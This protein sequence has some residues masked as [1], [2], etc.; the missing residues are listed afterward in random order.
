MQLLVGNKK[1]SA[2]LFFVLVEEKAIHQAL[3]AAFEDSR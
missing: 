3:F 1:S 2:T